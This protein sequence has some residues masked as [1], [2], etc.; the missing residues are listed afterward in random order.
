V[1]LFEIGNK[2]DRGEEIRP[3]F[4]M[5]WRLGMRPKA[6]L[7]NIDPDFVSLLSAP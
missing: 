4:F 2:H 1:L 5:G 6:S 3:G 7:D